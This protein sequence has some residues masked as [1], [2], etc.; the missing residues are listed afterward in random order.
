MRYFSLII[1]IALPVIAIAAFIGKA[2]LGY[3][4]STGR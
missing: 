3:G 4:F 2:K 1:R